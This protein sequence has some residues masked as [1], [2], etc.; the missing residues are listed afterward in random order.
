M[1]KMLDWLSQLPL[2]QASLFLFIVVFFRAQLT[3]WLG[4]FVHK[5]I[6][7]SGFG[8]KRSREQENK[9]GISAIQKYGWPVI[10]LSFLTVGFQSVVQIGAGLLDWKWTKYTLA[11]LP[12][13]LA[14]GFIYAVGGLAL[15][16]SIS[17]GS[18]GLL[19]LLLILIFLVWSAGYL[20]MKKIKI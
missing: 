14:W 10:P 9:A 17:T 18:I 19:I 8:K 13:Y 3:F 15:F 12:G 4:K 20:I 1:E 6:L 7:K 5:G 2:W 11:A 16:K